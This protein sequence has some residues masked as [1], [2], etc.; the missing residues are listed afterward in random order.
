MKILLKRGHT[1]M[2]IFDIFEPW[3]LY[4]RSRSGYKLFDTLIVFSEIYLKKKKKKD[5]VNFEKKLAND[6]VTYK[7]DPARNM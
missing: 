2:L 4:S 3:L 1:K 7:N 6:T 5:E